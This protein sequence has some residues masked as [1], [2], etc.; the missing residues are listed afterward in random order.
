MADNSEHSTRSL[1]A[2]NSKAGYEYFFDETLE[3]G[4][5]LTGTEVKSL[6]K[7][8]TT[9]TESHASLDGSEVFIHNLHIPE[10]AEANRF[11]HYPR[12]PRKLLLH[13]K[14]I[15]RLLGLIKQKRMT[16]IPL[17]MY[18]NKR[19]I[20]KILLAI[21]TGKKQHDKRAATKE[22]EWEVQKG[23]IARGDLN[24]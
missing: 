4:I 5:V 3:V 14:E 1:I 24:A 8:R 19:N 20:A 12:R 17:K 9:L 10:Y 16:L 15:K 11:N 22:R 2:N 23:R 18:F 21:A 7:N 6:R 13:K